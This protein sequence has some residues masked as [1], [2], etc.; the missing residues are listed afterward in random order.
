MAT[1]SLFTILAL[2]G[3]ESRHAMTLDIGG[4]YLNAVMCEYRE[5]RWVPL[6]P[7]G[8]TPIGGLLHGPGSGLRG[9]MK[10]PSSSSAASL[11]GFGQE[12]E[13]DEGR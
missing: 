6:S 10:F 11:Q 8:K 3:H 12:A 1:A 2:A 7:W 4:A 9:D 13:T 5:E